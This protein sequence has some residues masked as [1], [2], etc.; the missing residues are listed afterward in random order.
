MNCTV[1]GEILACD[2][3]EY[4]TTIWSSKVVWAL[5]AY[6]DVSG[7]LGVSSYYYHLSSHVLKPQRCIVDP[8]FGVTLFKL[9]FI[10]N[11]CYILKV[12]GSSFVAVI[13]KGNGRHPE[14]DSEIMRF[15]YEYNVLRIMVRKTSYASS[16]NS[17]CK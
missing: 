4:S 15:I 14:A 17:M 6:A 13:W 7:P 2:A 11:L 3:F 9:Y 1:T 8:H 16:P 5:C 10:E 12:R